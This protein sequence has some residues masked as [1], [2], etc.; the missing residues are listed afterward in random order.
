MKKILINVFLGL[1]F[2]GSLIALIYLAIIFA[3]LSE[4]P[5]LYVHIVEYPSQYYLAQSKL[6]EA[7]K[8]YLVLG[9]SMCSVSV[10]F[11]ICTA[12]VYNFVDF[13]RF[14]HWRKVQRNEARKRKIVRLQQQIDREEEE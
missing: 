12:V 1:V 6:I 14:L 3:Q 7:W 5:T 2:A 8:N 9:I 11:S 13:S 10:F 4:C